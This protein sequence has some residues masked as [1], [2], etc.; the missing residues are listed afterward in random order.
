[1]GPVWDF[2][3]AYRNAD[4]CSGDDYQGWAYLFGDVCGGDYWQVP[5]W[6]DR[7]LQDTVFTNT[8]SCRYQNLRL[9][10]LDTTSI[11]SYIDSVA[12]LL[13]QSQSRNFYQ[14]PILGI[15]V[16]PNPWPLAQTYEEE[17]LGLKKWFRNRLHW[18]DN[19]M[20]GYCPNVGQNSPT[21]QTVSLYPNPAGEFVLVNGLS[22]EH[23]RLILYDIRGSSV[24][25]VFPGG[26][27]VAL[28]HSI[29]EYICIR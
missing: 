27:P 24:L 22:G 11:F 28:G 15:Y 14:W 23:Y 19:N 25:D 9:T 17:I 2:D 29:R 3:L 18:L 10:V 26:M 1:M 16:W 7:L 21:I 5:F 6:W 4:Y 8:L 12:L 20:P 13:D